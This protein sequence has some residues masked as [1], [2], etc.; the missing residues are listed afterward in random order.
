MMRL[1][2]CAATRQLWTVNVYANAYGVIK[3]PIRP[4]EKDISIDEAGRRYLGETITYTR[5]LG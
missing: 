2:Y 1:Y 3:E 4:I 5:R